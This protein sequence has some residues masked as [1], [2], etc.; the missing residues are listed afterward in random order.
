MVRRTNQLISSNNR[1]TKEA[2]CHYMHLFDHL[3][4][5]IVAFN[6]HSRSVVRPTAKRV[7]V[8]IVQGVKSK[9]CLSWKKNGGK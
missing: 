7:I 5:I 3:R 2:A 6:F 4:S 8:N 9:S 1:S